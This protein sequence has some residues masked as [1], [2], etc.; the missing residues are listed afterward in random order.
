MEMT[1]TLLK[2]A[3]QRKSSRRSAIMLGG[4]A[5]AGLAIARSA[6]A[7]SAPSDSDIL[8][9]ALNLEYLEAQYYTL[10]TTG[11]TI[12]KLTS[13]P[14]PI[15]GGDGTAGGTVTVKA[16]PMVPFT[17]TLLQQYANETA[18]EERNHVLFLQGA[19]GSSYV[20]QPN[21][22]LLNSFNALAMVAGLGASFD[23]FASEA[24][25]LLGSFIFE[26]VGVTAYNGAAGLLSNPT[27][28][29]AAAGIL[30][31]E[32]YHAGSIRNRIY[33]A[34]PAAQAASTQIANARAT[35]SAAALAT[36]PATPDDIGVGTLPS[37]A[38][39]VVDADANALAFS[40]TTAQVLSIVYGGSKPGVFFPQGLNGNIK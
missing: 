20:A 25:F 14:V 30:A 36:P 13:N 33:A 38:S 17:T 29:F 34:G 40:R 2:N 7:Q 18:Q 19:L 26:D 1:E 27:Y 15:A 22:D 32:A 8:N 6:Q 12:D 11:M 28:L 21:I 5:L 35:L 16:N 23:P 37:G 10:A 3:E 4:A 31:V 39:T 24:N 9:F